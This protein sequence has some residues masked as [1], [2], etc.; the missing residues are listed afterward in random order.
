MRYFVR[1][2]VVEKPELAYSDFIRGCMSG[3]DNL[4]TMVADVYITGELEK[5][6]PK[7]TD[8]LEEKR[9]LQDLAARMANQ[10]EEVLPRF[11]DLAMQMTG[12]I[13]AG[14]SLYEENPAPGVFRWRYLRGSLAPFE[15]GITPRN[16]SPCG[17]T[18][19]QNCPVLTRHPEKVYN[20]ISDANIVLP[21]VLLVPL[22]LGSEEPMG[23]LW[24]VSDQ[25]NHFD[26]GHARMATELASFV[27]IALRMLR[28][29]KRLQAALEEQETLTKEM[30]HRVKNLFAVTDAMIRIS[31]KSA[32]SKEELQQTLSGRLHALGSAHALIRRSFSETG[33]DPRASDLAV[34]IQ[35]IVQP[36]EN[37]KQHASRFTIAGPTLAFGEH[38]LNGTALML[39]EL[40]TNAAKYGALSVADGRVD[41]NW[42]READKLVLNWI[43]YGGPRVTAAPE[44]TGFGSKLLHDTV[45]R[46]FAGG[47]EHHWLPDGLAVKIS[48]PLGK[49]LN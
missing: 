26:S 8:H 29:E 48:L 36:H 16:F 2:G 41:V 21:E 4:T 14:I 5:R 45:V 37:A 44:V 31:A 25:E 22:Y 17:I 34:L 1:C 20:W 24:I 18:L 30:S 40:T 11:V 6:A 3:L 19:D 46:Q 10:P 28:T 42:T 33:P 13:A 27:G 47:I 15:N 39:H 49:L 43:E 23:T 38:A 12:G 7:K 9:A 32:T 35:A